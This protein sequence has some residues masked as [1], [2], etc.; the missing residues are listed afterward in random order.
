[1][2][3]SSAL[4]DSSI[5][6]ASGTGAAIGYGTLANTGTIRSTGGIG[7][8]A[9]IANAA[10][11]AGTI[12][13]ATTGFALN[14]GRLTNSGTIESRKAAAITLGYGTTLANE[15]TGTIRAATAVDVSNGGMIV[16]RGGIVGNVAASAYSYGSTV[17][18]ADG[19]TLSGNLTLGQGYDLFLQTGDT[20]GLPARS[21]AGQA[22]TPSAIC[23]KPAAASR[24]TSGPGSTSRRIT[25]RHWVPTP[26]SH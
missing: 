22:S 17:Y 12:A 5:I 3:V 23:A 1:M 21:M 4:T 10:T 13:G 26:A 9:Y 16:N 25:S 19:G 8:M 18:V 11:N 15:A 24:S 14:S 6:T 7:V 20:T 2:S